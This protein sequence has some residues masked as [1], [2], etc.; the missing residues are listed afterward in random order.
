VA[1]PANPSFRKFPPVFPSNV[2]IGIE[3]PMAILLSKAITAEFQHEWINHA[4]VFLPWADIV[5]DYT[6]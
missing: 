2:T 3:E 6:N 4:Y 1:T 5:T